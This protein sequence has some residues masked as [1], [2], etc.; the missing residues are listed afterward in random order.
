LS[1]AFKGAPGGML[2]FAASLAMLFFC[3]DHVPMVPMVNVQA[4]L[5]AALLAPLAWH[6]EHLAS[7]SVRVKAVAGA[8]LAVGEAEA[9]GVGVGVGVLD[10]SVSK[11]ASILARASALMPATAVL[12]L[13][14]MSFFSTR[15][16]MLVSFVTHPF[17]L[18]APFQ[19]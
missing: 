5:A 2:P 15:A 3:P 7:A 8:G 11:K 16:R 1:V 10:F 18:S 12:V 9:P 13:G 17:S 19:W 6:P 4:F 14:G